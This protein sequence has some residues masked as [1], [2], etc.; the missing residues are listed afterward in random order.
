[1]AQ[2]FTSRNRR[3]AGVVFLLGSGMM[4]GFGDLVLGTTPSPLNFILY[5]GLCLLLV[6]LALVMAFVD[7]L[8][9]QQYWAREK[10]NLFESSLGEIRKE[11]RERDQK[12][13]SGKNSST[14]SKTS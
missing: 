11:I 5:W 14:P 12:S 7:V 8:C 6:I 9:I 4:L 10:K 1:M 3:V 13:G 2:C